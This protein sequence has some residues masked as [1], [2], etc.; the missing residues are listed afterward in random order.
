MLWGRLVLWGAL[1]ELK[2]STTQGCQWK[3]G[4]WGKQDMWAFLLAPGCYS[5]EFQTLVPIM[6][7]V[8]YNSVWC[9]FTRA[10]PP[11]NRN[12]SFTKG[13]GAVYMWSAPV[14]CAC[15]CV[16]ACVC[17][18]VCVRVMPCMYSLIYSFIY[19][20]YLLCFSFIL[21]CFRQNI[22]PWLF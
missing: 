18:H 10:H 22:Y 3:W 9:S 17:V 19:V 14:Y 16:R 20:S 21:F 4:S 1:I 2:E 15:A 12:R 13:H 6:R 11:H 7:N 8:I 5:F